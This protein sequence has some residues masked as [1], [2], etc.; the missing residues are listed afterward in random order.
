MFCKILVLLLVS[1]G[2]IIDAYGAEG[3]ELVDHVK[4]KD[5]VVSPRKEEGRDIRMKS[6]DKNIRTPEVFMHL[7]DKHVTI[8]AL[9]D[10]ITEVNHWT[11]G[12][13]NWVGMLS[14]GLYD[15]FPVGRTI[16]NSGISGNTM[17]HGLTRIERDVLRF[18]PDIVIIS[19]GMND[20]VNTTPE[21]FKAQLHQAVGMIKDKSDSV[22]IMR[23]PNPIIN[24]FSGKEL[25]KLPGPDGKDIDVNL[26][27]YAQ[28]IC[29]VAKEEETH[30]VDHYSM[31]V[32]SMK[33][34]CVG[35]LIMLMGNPQ[36]PNYQGHRRLYSELAPVFNANEN[37]FFE[38]ERI[39]KDMRK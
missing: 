25:T 37:F 12:G 28:I 13:Q 32:E 39:V 30:L 3:I 11:H 27:E 36:H 8:V 29:D 7:R 4:G 19:Y 14:M 38:W 33:S 6:V 23:T 21:A 2:C 9:G 22:I 26:K 20:C 17:E 10:S 5:V 24:M 18:D 31:W 1:C 16:I 34:S 15:V 35:D